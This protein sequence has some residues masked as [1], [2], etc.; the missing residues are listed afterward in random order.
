MRPFIVI[1]IAIASLTIA[2]CSPGQQGQKGEQG[3]PGRPFIVIA[4][5]IASLT[6]AGTRKGR[7]AIR[8]RLARKAPKA[9]RAFQVHKGRK[10]RRAIKGRPVRK[11]LRGKR[12]IRVRQDPPRQ[13]VFAW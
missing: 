9:S 13:L 10:G 3:P 2:G 4:I 6:I 12:E 11:D 8:G 1:A 7:R 5:A